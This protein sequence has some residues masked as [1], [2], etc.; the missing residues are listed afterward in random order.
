MLLSFACSDDK[1]LFIPCKLWYYKPGMAGMQ[2]FSPG[3][4]RDGQRHPG[5]LGK[6]EKR[7]RRMQRLRALRGAHE[8]GVRRR[9]RAGR[10]DAGRRRPRRAG[11]P[12]GSSLCRSGREASRQYAGDDRPRPQQGLHCEHGQVP[13]APQPGSPAGRDGGLPQ[14]AGPADCAG[15]P[16]ADRLPRADCRQGADP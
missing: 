11:R 9:E 14:L 13:A 6:P 1:I 16:E 4:F 15:K 7:M 5:Q 8:P 10:T 12:A 2:D 3:G